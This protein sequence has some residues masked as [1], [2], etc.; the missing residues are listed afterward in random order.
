MRIEMERDRLERA[1]ASQ[2]EAWKTV[3]ACFE[4]CN[5]LCEDGE[6]RRFFW[7][8]ELEKDT[9]AVEMRRSAMDD[10]G[11]HEHDYFTLNYVYEGACEINTGDGAFR[12]RRN[13]MCFLQPG[14]E[15]FV[16]AC[17]EEECILVNLLA[18]KEL[19][20]R[21][22]LPL[23]SDSPL[24]LSFFVQCMEEGEGQT[25]F[26]PD[27]GEDIIRNL[28]EVILVEDVERKSSYRQ[29]IQCAFASILIHFSRCYDDAALLAP[30][31]HHV[32]LDAVMKYL[33][34]NCATVS[35]ESAAEHFN[36][37]ASYLSRLLQKETGKSFSVLVRD[38]KLERAG[39]LLQETGLPVGMVASLVGYSHLGNFHKK[40]KERFGMTPKE[41][42]R[43]SRDGAAQ[44][45]GAVVLA[46]RAG[47]RKAQTDE[48]GRE[49]VAGAHGG[50]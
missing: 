7:P 32:N 34:E 49:P 6:T 10:C 29:I 11:L 36:Y 21:A 38:F 13:D 50:R 15:H 42:V 46:V 5:V 23:I 45:H 40:F 22:F 4:R 8:P 19:I 35:L 33:S 24:I 2:I 48:T 43:Q 31:E 41:F 14:A 3:K 28:I 16:S 47:S 20:Y 30:P 9:I 26:L 37:N 39:L 18:R 17:P 12:A 44:P 27:T 1:V 25:L